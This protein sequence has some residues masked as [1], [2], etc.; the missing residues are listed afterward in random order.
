MFQKVEKGQS[1]TFQ[2]ERMGNGKRWKRRESI[3]SMSLFL[4]S[5]GQLGQKI[6]VT[7]SE[8]GSIE[9]ELGLSRQNMRVMS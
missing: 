1:N 3:W 9:A 2:L 8:S 6:P 7:F 4:S 5:P